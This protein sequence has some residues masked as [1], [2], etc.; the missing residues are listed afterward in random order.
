MWSRWNN[1]CK[2]LTSHC[3]IHQGKAMLCLSTPFCY[4]NTA[5]SPNPQPNFSNILCP[6]APLT[7]RKKKKY[8]HCKAEKIVLFLLR[9]KTMLYVFRSIDPQRCIVFS[10]NSKKTLTIVSQKILT[11]ES[12]N[13]WYVYVYLKI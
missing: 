12:S 3:R 13:F 6:C 1:L 4:T 10:I 8:H 5:S 2:Q 9:F 7:K 11:R